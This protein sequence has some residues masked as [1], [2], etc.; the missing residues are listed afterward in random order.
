[1]EKQGGGRGGGRG[2]R[3]RG[4]IGGREEGVEEREG[5]G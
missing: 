4:W 1:M 2:K 5:D 3:K